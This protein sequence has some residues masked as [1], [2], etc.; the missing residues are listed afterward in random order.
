L[1]DTLLKQFLIN[2]LVT[3][4]IAYRVSVMAGYAELGLDVLGILFAQ[5]RQPFLLSARETVFYGDFVGTFTIIAVSRR[6]SN[7]NEQHA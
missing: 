2:L 1:N 3:G 5:G 7:L 4:A 6:A